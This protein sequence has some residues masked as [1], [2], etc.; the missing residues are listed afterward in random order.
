MMPTNKNFHLQNVTLKVGTSHREMDKLSDPHTV[1]ST[2][3]CSTRHI[4]ACKSDKTVALLSLCHHSPRTKR[5]QN[6]QLWLSLPPS[7]TPEPEK[8]LSSMAVSPSF[9]LMPPQTLLSTTPLSPFLHLLP[10]W[11]SCAPGA[12]C[13]F[14]SF[15]TL[16]PMS[17]PWIRPGR[18]AYLKLECLSPA[19][20]WTAWGRHLC[21]SS[22]CSHTKP[23]S[24]N[25]L[26]QEAM[27]KRWIICDK[28]VFSSN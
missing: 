5:R 4:S 28:I 7:A 3:S 12:V 1:S 14:L 25:C 6:A 21:T 23:S 26:R 24:S 10:S 19:R 16:V 15:S 17:T 9:H 20:E 11:P 8:K 22:D 13:T 27:I 18:R 2:A